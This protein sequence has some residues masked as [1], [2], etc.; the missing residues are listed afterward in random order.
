MR[1]HATYRPCIK[2]R[3][4]N[5]FPPCRGP[6]R[7][8]PQAVLLQV[9]SVHRAISSNV[10]WLTQDGRELEGVFIDPHFS[11]EQ[12]AALE[13]V[14]LDSVHLHSV[15]EG[16]HQFAI[17]EPSFLRSQ[18]ES[19]HTVAEDTQLF[20]WDAGKKTKPKTTSDVFVLSLIKSVDIVLR[21]N[22]AV[23]TKHNIDIS[24]SYMMKVDFV[25]RSVK[26]LRQVVALQVENSD[27]GVAARATDRELASAQQDVE[28]LKTSEAAAQVKLVENAVTITALRKQ[29]KELQ[30][31]LVQAKASGDAL[32]KLE[33]EMGNLHAVHRACDLKIQTRDEELSQMKD[34]RSELVK[35]HY[36]QREEMISRNRKLMLEKETLE[37]ERDALAK[38][39]RGMKATAQSAASQ[40]SL[41][42]KPSEPP[43]GPRAT[44]PSD[45]R[46]QNIVVVRR[47]SAGCYRDC[48]KASPYGMRACLRC[49]QENR[50]VPELLRRLGPAEDA[51]S[52][53]ASRENVSTSQQQG[54]MPSLS[55][56]RHSR[57]STA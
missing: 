5:E 56:N 49:N 40:Q 8:D 44:R 45:A 28:R 10:S 50:P 46:P 52:Q 48:Y 16:V 43:L 17:M 30:D 2:W 20:R 29:N 54:G 27:L 34:R 13:A 37:S 32:V 57:L 24:P 36:E 41:S 9:K 15:I 21:D 11:Q 39:L 33:T 55:P 4:L 42:T 18:V 23:A 53:S 31:E 19:M 25:S 22:I 51:A 14:V 7:M 12:A 3:C 6:R 1:Y 26:W 35:A 47:R 38:E